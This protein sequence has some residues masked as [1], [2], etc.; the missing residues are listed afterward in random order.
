MTPELQNAIE[1]I[2][3][4]VKSILDT[5]E[6]ESG[7]RQALSEQGFDLT[8]A[9]KA[10]NWAERGPLLPFSAIGINDTLLGRA[11]EAVNAAIQQAGERSLSGGA[12][13]NV[14]VTNNVT[15]IGTNL[16]DTDPE[17][18]PPQPPYLGE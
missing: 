17:R 18:N 6:T 4:R 5:V 3:G 7:K 13:V 14:N 10:Y 16:A 9:L 1:N 15:N 11:N 8:G 12:P 2:G